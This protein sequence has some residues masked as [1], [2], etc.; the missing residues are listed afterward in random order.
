MFNL[1]NKYLQLKK[2]YTFI[3][4]TAYNSGGVHMFN[5]PVL[6]YAPI[7]WVQT[8]RYWIV[9]YMTRCPKI[10]VFKNTQGGGGGSYLAHGLP[11]FKYKY[12]Y[13][14]CRNWLVEMAISTNQKPAIYRNLYENTAP[15]YDERFSWCVSTRI[16]RYCLLALHG[17]IGRTN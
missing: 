5:D 3:K 2:K 4:L 7:F 8:S 13:H 14:R 9:I 16:S 11:S 15:A 12:L 10:T 17:S 6:F 1:W